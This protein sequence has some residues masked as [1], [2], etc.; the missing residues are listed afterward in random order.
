MRQLGVEFTYVDPTRPT[1]FAEAMRPTTKLVWVE[2]PTNPLL[3]LCDIAAVAELC[4][5]RGVLLAVDN[6]FCTPVIQRP[7]ALGADLVVHSTTKYLNGH[8]D[9][10]GGAILGSD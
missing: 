6:T 3:K 5:K 9:V 4:R 2:T 1:A 10:V 7:L 8:A